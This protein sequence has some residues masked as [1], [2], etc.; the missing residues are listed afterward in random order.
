MV[1]LVLVSGLTLNVWKTIM[2]NI[3]ITGCGRGLGRSLYNTLYDWRN[4]IVPLFRTIPTY[5]VENEIIGNIRH[6][7]T[8]DKISE[9]LPKYNVNVL[10]NNAGVYTSKKLIEMNDDEIMNI[11]D[12]NLT[13]QIQVTR[14]AYKYFSE[15]NKGL[16]ININSLAYHHPSYNETVYCAS[17]WGFAGFSKALQMESI[18][19][20]IKTVDLFIGAMHTDMTAERVGY[21]IDPDDVSILV[22]DI[23]SK[24]D[25]NTFIPTE[26]TLRRNND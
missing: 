7:T 25:N 1:E 8:L 26:I 10:I 23:I 16:I 18:G 21:M 4:T 6:A 2:S 11:I 15:K 19:K 17:K 24:H 14:R 12:T 5:S 3:L 13:A 9:A 20:N 22:K